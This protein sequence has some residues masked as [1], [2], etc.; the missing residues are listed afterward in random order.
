MGRGKRVS[1]Q[2]SVGAFGNIAAL[3]AMREIMT[4][5]SSSAA[6]VTLVSVAAPAADLSD[7]RRHQRIQFDV[8]Q[9]MRVGISGRTCRRRAGEPVS[10]A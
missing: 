3:Q 1:W 10:A 7:R 2:A 8:P 4:P 5:E 9:P 6:A